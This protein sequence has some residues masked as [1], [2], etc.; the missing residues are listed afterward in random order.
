MAALRVNRTNFGRA[1]WTDVHY[2]YYVDYYYAGGWTMVL[3]CRQCWLFPRL[4]VLCIFCTGL[5][6]M[7]WLHQ[8]FGL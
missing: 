7:T 1:C 2:Y 8:N 4:A 5:G 3:F 6:L